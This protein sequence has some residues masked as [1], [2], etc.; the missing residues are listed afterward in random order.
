MQRAIDEGADFI[1]TDIS[2]TKDGV[3]IC[4]H[5]VTLDETTDIAEHKE[6]RNR[7]R[8]YEVQGFNI[9]GFFTGIVAILLPVPLKPYHIFLCLLNVYPMLLRPVISLNTLSRIFKFAVVAFQVC[10]YLYFELLL[11]NSCTVDF[12][13]EE[14]KT[15]R[16]KQRYS[17]RDQQYNG[18][19]LPTILHVFEIRSMI[20]YLNFKVQAISSVSNHIV[21]ENDI[22][23]KE[24][25]N[26]SEFSLVM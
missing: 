15:L 10:L 11:L 4:F 19:F 23:H 26:N 5:D 1:E 2:S 21:L 16:V 14:L 8:T 6:F 17:F 13:L 3:L 20:C 22:Y 25:K 18:E 7:K 9:T 12:T 24:L